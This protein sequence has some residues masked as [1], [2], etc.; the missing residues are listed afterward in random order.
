[1]KIIKFITKRIIRSTYYILAFV[2][3][4]SGILDL[5]LKSKCKGKIL[6]VFYHEVGNYLHLLGNIV[7]TNKHFENQVKFL[8]KK[9]YP[10]GIDD[11]ERSLNDD[12]IN[13]CLLLITFDGGYKGNI[14]N[15]QPILE[16]YKAPGLIYI[17]TNSV[18]KGEV[19]WTT[20]LSFLI[21]QTNKTKLSLSYDGTDIYNGS[22]V[23][24]KKSLNTI[25]KRLYNLSYETRD[26][27]LSEIAGKLDV[28]MSMLDKVFMSWSDISNIKKTGLIS[29][30][31]HTITHPRLNEISENEAKKEI[32]QSKK[33]IEEKTGGEIT[34]FCYPDGKIGERIVSLVKEAGYRSATT[35]INGLNESNIN[36]F[37]LKRIGG[38]NMPVFVFALK[39]SGLFK[40]L[41]K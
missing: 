4:Y 33:I 21:R 28:D 31:S 26:A 25:K 17:V 1:M 6:I 10:I 15:A 40:K 13:G 36:P 19:P 27:I 37:L 20:K 14:L 39:I 24:K 22:I 41:N 30:G 38:G 23:N 32:F 2:L 7:T 35:T 8:T 12:N 3:Y 9:F 16:N 5:I 34:S 18:E 29:I 11:L